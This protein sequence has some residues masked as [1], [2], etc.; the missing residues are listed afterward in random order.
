MGAPY[1][2]HPGT[3]RI[4]GRWPVPVPLEPDE[5]F[6]TWL[7]RVALAQGV[8]PLVLTGLLWPQWRA[9]TIDLDRGIDNERLTPLAHQSGLTTAELEASF[10]L[11]IARAIGVDLSPSV[12]VWHWVLALGS[13]NR[14]RHGGLQYCPACLAGDARPYFRLQ[15]RLAWHTSCPVHLVSLIDRCTQCSA[16]VEPN[17]LMAD[18]SLTMCSSC[19]TDL[20]RA[21]AIAV[22]SDALAF[23]TT[24]DAVALTGAGQY[25]CDRVS[26]RDWFHLA[27]YHLMLLRCAARSDSSR[28]KTCLADLDPRVADLRRPVTGLGFEMLPTSER[29][30]ICAI[31][32]S[33]LAAGS[34]RLSAAGLATGATL[35]LDCS[36]V[37][38]VLSQFVGEL[39]GPKRPRKTALKAGFLAPA[40]AHSVVMRWAQFRRKARQMP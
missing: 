20:R 15:W 35:R 37:P 14:S 27:R 33:L 26:A 8:D 31:V 30:Q 24:A 17:R 36:T 12:G 19:R 29:G 34:A 25:G 16:P 3:G 18:A 1:T 39:H 5:L 21:R 4:V 22:L 40:S 7:V 10:L 32:G 6:S 9:L 2:W 11:P 28:L 13:R 23:Q 38:L